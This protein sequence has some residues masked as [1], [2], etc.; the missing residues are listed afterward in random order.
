MSNQL[1]RLVVK[2]KT[3]QE[4]FHID[5]RPLEHQLS[6]LDFW[7]WACS[8]LVENTFRGALAEFYVASALGCLDCLRDSLSCHDLITKDEVTI[9]VKSAAY[10]QSWYQKTYS[11]IRFDIE[12]KMAFDANTGVSEKVAKRHSTLYVFC[13]NN[14]KDKTTLDPLNLD[15]WIFYV[16]PTKLLEEKVPALKQLSL[17]MLLKLGPSESSYQSLKKTIEGCAGIKLS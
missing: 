15:Q 11:A 12:P 7:Q 14:H 2:R 8:D 3:G 10:L 9:Q 4:P 1:S 16:M 5:G 13:L 17:D 6:L